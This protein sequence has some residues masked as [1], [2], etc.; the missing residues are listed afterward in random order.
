MLSRSTIPRA[1]HPG[2]WWIWAVG[3]AVAASATTN[4]LLLLT[5]VAV[6]GFV[7]TARRGD[8]P[9]ARAFRLYLLL[10]ASIIVV[11]VVLHVL[12]GWKFGT[13]VI[14]PLPT[15]TLPRWASGIQIGGTVRLEGLIATICEALRLATIIACIGA[16]NALANPKRLLRAA[17]GALQELGAAVVVSISVAPQLVESVQRVRRARLLRGDEA[18]GL[19]SVPRVALPVLQDTLD[20]SLLLAA[21]MDARGYGRERAV[22]RGERRL[23]SSLNLTG[24]LLLALGVYGVL[25]PS[26][27]AW[28][29]WPALGL[30]L[31]AATVA[32][33]LA[34]RGRTQSSYRPD[35][36]RIPEW[37]TA[38]AGGAAAAL[39]LVQRHIAPEAL[40][41][42]LAP[43]AV[44][45]LPPLALL[46]LLL[47]LLPAVLT[48]PVPPPAPRILHRGARIGHAR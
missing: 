17:P 37:I 41:M 34:G 35:P 36:W 30:G 11:R 6:A 39:T 18:R 21:A 12:V 16:A 15:L 43:L 2:A 13:E 20:R 48:P 42:P 31:V 22:S 25:D 8:W 44:P 45:D 33:A 14:L 23:V 9:W 3:L 19:R 27:S 40:S 24:L 28:L 10:G 1:V 5:A 38:G 26:G 47:A 46:G 4:P 29:G 7:V 32:T